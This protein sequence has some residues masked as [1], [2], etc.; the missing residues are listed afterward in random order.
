M[1]SATNLIQ[2]VQ[3]PALLMKQLQFVFFIKFSFINE[4]R[5][6]ELCLTGSPHNGDRHC[7]ERKLHVSSNVPDW[8]VNWF[9][10]IYLTA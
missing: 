8:L 7:S 1:P 2:L 6:A 5:K 4:V 9:I 3:V 10:Y